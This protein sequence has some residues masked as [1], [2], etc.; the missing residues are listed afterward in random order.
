MPK[1]KV[2]VRTLGERNYIIDAADEDAVSDIIYDAIDSGVAE[3]ESEYINDEI[4][5][6]IKE[7]R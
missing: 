4:I 5:D 1:F 2:T 3:L 6:D 7:V